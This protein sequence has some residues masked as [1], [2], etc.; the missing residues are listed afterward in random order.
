MGIRPDSTVE[1]VAYSEEWP[2]AFERERVALRAAVGDVATSIEHIGSTAVPGLASKPTIDILI[3]VGSVDAFRDR[4]PEIE[5]IGYDFREGNAFVGNP[6]H[7][8]LRK[9][10]GAKRTHHLHVLP[11]GSPEIDDYRLFRDA[12]RS[13]PAFAA[14]YEELKVDLAGRHADHRMRYVT[15]KEAWVGDVLAS[16]RAAR[17]PGSAT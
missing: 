1:V 8:F 11:E 2:A 4:I 5:A 10:V 12:L 7:L 16:L 14:R 9:V 6:D 13:D 17:E 3:V 15:E